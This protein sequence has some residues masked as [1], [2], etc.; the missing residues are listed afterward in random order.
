MENAITRLAATLCATGSAAFF[1]LLG[2]FL[3]VPG[4]EGRLSSLQ[5]GELQ[6]IVTALVAGTATAWVALHLFFLSDQRNPKGLA[7]LRTTVLIGQ[8]TAL[9][10][11]FIWTQEKIQ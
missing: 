2:V 8:I 4:N 3:A 11:G 9:V 7:I 1:W 5:R 10:A 6:I